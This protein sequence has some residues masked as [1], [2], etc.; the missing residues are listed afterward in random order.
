MTMSAVL[1]RKA[2]VSA[3]AVEKFDYQKRGSPEFPFLN[4]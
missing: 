3:N 2:A 1:A 4:F